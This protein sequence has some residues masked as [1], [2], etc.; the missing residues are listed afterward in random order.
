[1]ANIVKLPKLEVL[2]I[3]NYGFYG[4]VWRLND[5]EIFNQL[6]FLLIRTNDLK[7][8]KA[9]SVNFPM[10]QRVVLRTCIYLKEIP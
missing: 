9:G 8:W 10:L 4:D 5:G 6:K 2:K 3:K 7:Q 1:M